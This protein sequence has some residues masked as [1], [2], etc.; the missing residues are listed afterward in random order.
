MLFWSLIQI[1]H[2]CGNMRLALPYR[3]PPLDQP[4]HAAVTGD[5]GS[6]AIEKPCIRGRPEDAP[7]GARHVGRKVMSDRRHGHATL[8]AT[9]KRTDRDR[10]FG[11]QREASD[12][13][14]HSSGLLNR[15]YAGEDRLRCRNFFGDRL[16]ATF[17]GQ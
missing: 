15:G 11:I 3:V 8:P 12:L 16:L 5:L 14:G 17:L 2:P 9:G 13:V 4:V 6:P 7:R 10:G 1:E